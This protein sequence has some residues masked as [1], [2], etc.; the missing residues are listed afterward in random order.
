MCQEGKVKEARNER[1]VRNRKV[2]GREGVLVLEGSVV[3]VVVVV[4][5]VELEVKEGIRGNINEGTEGGQGR[6]G[7][8]GELRKKG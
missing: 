2:E 6:R 7:G 4:V 5:V 1:E 8:N 3:V